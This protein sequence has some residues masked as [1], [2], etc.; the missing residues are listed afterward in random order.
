MRVQNTIMIGLVLALSVTS[1]S[2][3]SAVSEGLLSVK[4]IS[5]VNPIGRPVILRGVNYVGYESDTPYP[6]AH[7]E[8]D[9]KLFARLGFNV[10]RLPISW[11]PLEPYPGTF[12]ETYLS[13]Y[14]DKDVRWA[15]K[16]GIYIVLD[17]HQSNWGSKFGGSGTPDWIANHYP[18]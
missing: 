12:Y 4:E 7:T 10:V 5:I 2:T 3:A 15:K 9:Y 11:S 1:G 14:V 6:T 8:S 18:P 17:M 13:N 16:Y